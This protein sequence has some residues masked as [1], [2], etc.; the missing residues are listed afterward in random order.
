MRRA[1]LLLAMAVLAG[2]TQAQPAPG[3]AGAIPVTTDPVQVGPTPVEILANGIAAS[4]SVIT[5]RTR[6]DGQIEQILVQEGQLVQRGQPMI[7]LDSRLSRALLQQQEAQLA[8][9]RALLTRAQQDLVRYQAL[10]R[11]SVASQ[12]RFELATSDAAAAAAVV[13]ADEALVAQGRLNVEFATITAEIEGRL[14]SIPL[15]AGNFVRQA[16]T[17][18]ITTLTQMNPILVQFNVPERWL[19]MIQQAM[20]SGT[21][22]RVRVTADGDDRPPVDGPVVFV[23]SAVD[24]TTGTIT[25]KARLDNSEFRLWPGRY[26]RVSLIPRTDP[27]ALTVAGAAVQTGQNGRFV[28]ILGADGIARRRPVELIRIAGDRAV[29]RAEL[30]AGEKVIVD[31]AQRVTEGSRAVE[32]AP[33][34]QRVT[35]AN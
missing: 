26:V 31:G 6:V 35:S 5:I 24:T 14:G 28:F 16:E 15:R 21:V 18:A 4:E 25:L 34:P 22:P 23:D 17:T 29:V 9:D 20:A 27:N 33:P 30:A 11:E 7:I 8:R 19:P 12:Q 32:R 2:P 10:G 3:A 13:R 1:A